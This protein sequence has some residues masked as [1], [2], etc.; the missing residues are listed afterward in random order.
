MFFKNHWADGGMATVPPGL[1]DA[2][3]IFEQT[4][5]N[6]GYDRP[7]AE[8][9]FLN[10]NLQNQETFIDATNSYLSYTLEEIL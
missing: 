6:Y 10:A 2:R 3:A 8:T 5:Y 1:I 9:V 7:P 4:I